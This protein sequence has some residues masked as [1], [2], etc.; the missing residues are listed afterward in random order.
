MTD[1]HKIKAC[2]FCGEDD[3]I[4]TV[5]DQSTDPETW[6]IY[7]F[8]CKATGPVSADETVCVA[9]WNFVAQTRADRELGKL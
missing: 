1:E 5:V 2:P 7:C 3:N 8:G 4:M 9:R 6:Q